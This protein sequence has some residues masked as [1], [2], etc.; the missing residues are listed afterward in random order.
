MNLKENLD[1]QRQQFL[2]KS[3][4]DVINV[5]SMATEQLRESGIEGTCLTTGDTVPNVIMQ[6]S[7]GPQFMLYDTLQRGPLVLSFF[8]GNW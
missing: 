8:R 3:P 5:I 7:D 4:Q 1:R 6:S 2:A